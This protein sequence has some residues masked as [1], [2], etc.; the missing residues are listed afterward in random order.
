MVEN[1]GK[2]LKSPENK[3]APIYRDLVRL[4]KLKETQKTL[5]DI[6]DLLTHLFNQNLKLNA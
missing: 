1:R 2:D 3:K 4:S 5:F 6:L